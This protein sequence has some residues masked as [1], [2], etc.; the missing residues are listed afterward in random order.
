MNKGNKEGVSAGPGL[1]VKLATNSE[2]EQ[3]GEVV[4]VYVVVNVRVTDPVRYAEY[5]D[6]APDTIARY[7]G[8]YLARGGAVEVIE[9]EWD[10][11][12]LVLLE[13]ENMKRF[14]EWYDSPEYTPLKRLRGEVTVTELVVVEGL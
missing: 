7:G 8:R 1:I 14:R 10:P 13:F 5:R 6:K 11:Q 3:G 9:G 12:R 2:E 4:A